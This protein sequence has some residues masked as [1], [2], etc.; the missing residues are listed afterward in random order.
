MHLRI[1]SSSNSLYFLYIPRIECFFCL[2]VASR[3]RGGCFTLVA[4]AMAAF[5]RLPRERSPWRRFDRR[6]TMRLPGH[7][8]APRDD[9]CFRIQCGVWNSS[10]HGKEATLSDWSLL[11]RSVARIQICRK[12][13]GLKTTTFHKQLWGTWVH[14]PVIVILWS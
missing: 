11:Y 2:N 14:G 10:I 12:W 5:L 3:F 8:V 6:G 9:P 4:H 13:F 1:H 7:A